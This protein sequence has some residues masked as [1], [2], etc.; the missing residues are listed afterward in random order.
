MRTKIR[1]IL[2]RA[3]ASCFLTAGA[4]AAAP[5]ISYIISIDPAD[6]SG[7]DVEMRIPG[8]RGTLR[9]AMAAHPEYDDR[10]WRYI[11]NFSAVDSRGKTFSLAKEQDAV[12]RIKN[13]QGNVIVRY[14]LRLPAQQG[15]YRDAWKPFLTPTGGMVGDLHSLMYVVGRE[16]ARARLTL[17]MPDKWKA[18]TGL[19]PTRHPLTFTGSTELMLDS[20][21][22]IGP[23]TESEFRAGGVSHKVAFWSPPDGP[24]FDAEAIV[25]SVRKISDEA[26]KAFGRPPYPR[27]V[28]LFQ[29]GG[30]AGLEHLT[31]VNV[32][33]SPNLEDFLQQV[34]HEYIHV[35]NLMDVK[36]RERVGVRSR[37]AEPTGVLWWNEGAT[38]M[39]ADLVI[40]R[41]G[42]P[43]ETRTRMKRLESAI[44]RY[45]TSPGYYTLSAEQVSRGD[46]HPALLG[47]TSASTHLQGEVL[48][49]MLDFKIRDVT[50]GRRNVVDV[51]R[52]LASRFDFRRGIVNRDIENAVAQ[53]CGCKIGPFFQE[54][55]YGAKKIDFDHYLRLIGMRAEIGT[56]PA[57]GRDGSP[58]ADVRIGPLSGEPTADG[59]RIRIT[60]PQSAWAKAGLH[61]GDV[62]TSID[63]SPVAN[64]GDLRQGLQKLKIGDVA[65]VAMLR[66]GVSREVNVAIRGYSIATVQLSEIP[67]ATPEQV[68]LR[69]AWNTAN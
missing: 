17:L 13:A 42:V 2:L 25:S 57:V 67:A 69:D 3:L 11:E 19:E 4:F 24:A 47:D 54:Y 33:L 44:A 66:D 56:T 64:W 45:L 18:A 16:S 28:F 68:R 63:G 52:L 46:S 55:I 12:W 35:W 21:V 1:L 5:P 40:R 53:V 7:F 29:N 58:A 48:S 43:G 61:T 15:T 62:M 59:L 49:T 27:Y 38:I 10:Y 32:G 20:P 26:I 41:A 39:F 8:A 65:R 9:V 36:P 30:Q 14:R 60:N 50:D 37:F 6:L 51:M 23:F 22:M 31:S 34:T